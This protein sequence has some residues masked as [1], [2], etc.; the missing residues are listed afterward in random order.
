VAMEVPL[1]AIGYVWMGAQ[2]L[3]PLAELRP[4][5]EGLLLGAALGAAIA[6]LSL[7]SLALSRR[8]AALRGWSEFVEGT[9]GRYLGPAGLPALA[10]LSI[11]A[12]LGEEVF[13]RGAL[14]GAIGLVPTALVFGIAHVGVPKREMLPYF[15]YTV[16]VGLVFGFVRLGQP[17]FP[18]VIAHALVDLID[19][20]Y[21]HFAYARSDPS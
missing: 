19:T 6:A 16:L 18:L 1:F 10:L 13:F 4:T 21:L 14:Q 7:G 9:L 11:C 3:D 17:L 15:A 5:Q 20:A 8:V 2:G 12:G